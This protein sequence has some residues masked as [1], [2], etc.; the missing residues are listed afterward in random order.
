MYFTS[1][2]TL[3]TDHIEFHDY[4]QIFVTVVSSHI[5]EEFS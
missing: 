1:S 4:Y 5:T 2:T 3:G